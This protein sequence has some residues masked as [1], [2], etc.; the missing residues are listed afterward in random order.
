MNKG[1]ERELKKMNDAEFIELRKTLGVAKLIRNLKKDHEVTNEEIAERLGV[2]VPEVK[3]MMN[4]CYSFTL[5]I[6]SIIEAYDDELY[7]EPL[8]DQKE[9]SEEE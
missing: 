4:G 2:Q 8:D 6:I 7:D 5:K 1:L 9:G 3:N